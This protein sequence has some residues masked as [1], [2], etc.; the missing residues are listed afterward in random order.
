MHSYAG[1]LAPHNIRVKPHHPTACSTPM[2]VNEFFGA[3]AAEEPAIM[4]AY[5]DALQVP[6]L[7][8]STSAEASCIW[9]QMMAGTSRAIPSISM[10]GRPRCR[11][12]VDGL[13]FGDL[14]GPK[15]NKHRSGPC[16]TISPRP[17][18][19]LAAGNHPVTH[20]DGL[21]W[22]SQMHIATSPY[23]CSVTPSTSGGARWGTST[24]IP[25]HESTARP[26]V[27]TRPI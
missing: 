8:Q 14:P 22:G 1:R 3:F 27:R 23:E 13:H 2:V 5:T 26:V 7:S 19:S 24:K 25:A 20:G 11:L 9:F 16:R 18:S 6:I 12:V 4:A 10:P 15:P 17:A 21:P